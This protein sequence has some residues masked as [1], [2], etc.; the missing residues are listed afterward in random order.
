MNFPNQLRGTFVHKLA[1][2]IKF[3]LK[4]SE[5]FSYSSPV[6]EINLTLPSNLSNQDLNDYEADFISDLAEELT[7]DSVFYDVGAYVGYI[8]KAAMNCGISANQIH[9][10][11]A[12]PYR[13]YVLRKNCASVGVNTVNKYVGK[14][15]IKNNNI[16]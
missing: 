15:N 8:T 2:R 10:F 6:G 14:K 11:E 12:V 7:D 13:Y 5:K 16:Y 4:E 3:L 1:H 9:S